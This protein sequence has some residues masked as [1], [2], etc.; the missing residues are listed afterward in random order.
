MNGIAT[1]GGGAQLIANR[2][3]TLFH[4][5]ITAVLNRSLGLWF[6]L[7]ECVL[8]RDLLL[9]TSDVRLGYGFIR[10]AVRNPNI[11][12]VVIIAHSQGGII[13]SGWAV[14]GEHGQH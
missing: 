9:I 5:K 4:R 12:R 13:A 1:T 7:I 2:L 11:K 14:S 8:Q 10:D 6:D 3:E